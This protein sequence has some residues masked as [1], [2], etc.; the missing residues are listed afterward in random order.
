MYF[1]FS[2]VSSDLLCHSNGGSGQAGI[3]RRS[4][5]TDKMLTESIDSHQ[6]TNQRRNDMLYVSLTNKKTLSLQQI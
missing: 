3:Y 1:E 5:E 4:E 2:K 6:R